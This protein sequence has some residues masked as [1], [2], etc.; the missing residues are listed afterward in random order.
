MRQPVHTSVS[1][2]IV[3]AAF[4]CQSRSPFTRTPADVALDEPCRY[5]GTFHRESRWRVEKLREH[6]SL[7]F[8]EWACMTHEL[9]QL[10]IVFSAECKRR[11]VGV[12]EIS[13]DQRARYRS[14][15]E[16]DRVDLADCAVLSRDLTPLS[17]S[18]P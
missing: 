2:L 15:V 9:K 11:E 14:C 8:D 1:L 10:D 6:G 5:M 18:C 12:A 7:S 3:A 13:D 16:P 4:G 17:G